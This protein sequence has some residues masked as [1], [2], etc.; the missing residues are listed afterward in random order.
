MGIHQSIRRNVSPFDP[1][2]CSPLADWT[3]LCLRDVEAIGQSWIVN[4]IVKNLISF[5]AGILFF[6]W[7]VIWGVPITIRS[8]RWCRIQLSSIRSKNLAKDIEK[9][10]YQPDSHPPLDVQPTRI[11]TRVQRFRK[12]LHLT[13]KSDP[14]SLSL[15]CKAFA[16]TLHDNPKENQD[17]EEYERVSSS[18][19]SF[20]FP[21]YQC[22]SPS[23]D[24]TSRSLRVRSYAFPPQRLPPPP[25]TPL[26]SM[27][28]SYSA[29]QLPPSYPTAI[30][31][32]TLD[33]M[34]SQPARPDSLTIPPVL[35]C[36][37]PD[38]SLTTE[39]CR[40]P[41][42]AYA[43]FPKEDATCGQPQTKDT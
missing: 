9:G 27:P 36:L 3:K 32:E 31:T 37:N 11:R 43:H 7:Y 6:M 23:T 12:T 38:T 5:E 15:Q 16:P 14:S 34:L 30:S 2:E 35:Q 8:F 22:S 40:T 29:P 17:R 25:G 28:I 20:R 1:T 42:P 21:A 24:R 33:R 13:S 39:D 10:C 4:L 18:L 19:N 26:P 41:P